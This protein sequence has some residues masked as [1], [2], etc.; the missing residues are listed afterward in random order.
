MALKNLYNEVENEKKNMV[1]E[2]QMYSM[3]L[4]E[5]I[6]EHKKLIEIL[7]EGSREELLAEAESQ[8]DELEECLKEH[9]MSEG[10]DNEEENDD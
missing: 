6:E 4:D 5:F 9:G 10:E 8:E 7:R 2:D 1:K 3:P